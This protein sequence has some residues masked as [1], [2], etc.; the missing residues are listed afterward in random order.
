MVATFPS[1]QADDEWSPL[2]SVIVGRAGRACFPSAPAPMIEATM[3]SAHTHRFQP[4]SPFDET[5]IA[6]AEAELDYFA[7]ILQ[8][9]GI[10]VYRPPV[11]INWLDE[12]G[13]TGAMPRDGLM[14]VQNTLIEACF[15]WPCR[16]REIEIAFKPILDDLARDARVTIVRRPAS[17]FAETLLDSNESDDGTNSSSSSRTGGANGTG[18]WVINNSRP[19]FDTADFM[20]F[21][22]TIIG[23]F[24]HVTNQAGVDYIQAQLPTGYKIEM[25]EVDDPHAMHIDATILP[26]REGLLAYNPKKVSEAALRK[27]AVLADWDLRPY[28]FTPKEPGEDSPPLYM[29]SPWLCLNALVLDGERV[30][31]EISDVQ[32]AQWFESLGMKCIRCPFKHVNSI[33]GSFHCATVDLVREKTKASTSVN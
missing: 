24:S 33:G 28:P 15:A 30:V 10:N 26:L 22:Q 9:E 19:A 3:P 12:N 14:S 25:L 23:Q 5:L 32:T 7:A 13:Y 27:H 8:A 18:Q 1:V 4:H 17:S 31:V 6:K 11:G 20:R 21:G 29:T 16:N 2:K